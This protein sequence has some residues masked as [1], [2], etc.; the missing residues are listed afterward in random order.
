MSN[1]F[2]STSAALTN[3]LHSLLLVMPTAAHSS[4][5][6]KVSRRYVR[7]NALNCDELDISPRGTHLL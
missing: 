1:I 3:G 7:R 4:R 6:T 5:D 2:F